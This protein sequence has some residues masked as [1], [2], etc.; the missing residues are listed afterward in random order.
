MEFDHQLFDV[1]QTSWIGKYGVERGP[2]GALDVDLQ[3][4]DCRLRNVIFALVQIFT[5][6]K[7]NS[8]RGTYDVSVLLLSFY[9]CHVFN[10]RWLKFYGELLT[11]IVGPRRRG[12]TPVRYFRKSHSKRRN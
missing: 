9:T 6:T 3:N 7:R 11:A 10:L 8:F 2:L 4:V 1:G 12:N 5:N